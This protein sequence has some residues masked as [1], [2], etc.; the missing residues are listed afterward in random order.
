[1]WRHQGMIDAGDLMVKS[2][3][4]PAHTNTNNIS[5]AIG[6]EGDVLTINSDGKLGIGTTNFN[7]PQVTTDTKLVVNGKALFEE[8]KVIADVTPDY[9]FQKYY[10]G[11]SK[12]KANYQM[13]TLEE[14][15]AYTKANHHLPEVPSATKMKEEGMQLKEMTTILLQKIEELLPIFKFCEPL[16]RFGLAS[17]QTCIGFLAKSS[18]L[19]KCVCGGPPFLPC[20]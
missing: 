7:Q 12:L 18:P 17:V 8:V 10:T 19:S 11:T 1:M 9:V 14:V 20:H 5:S 6:G 3:T 15:E 13:P 4:M 16:L 2:N